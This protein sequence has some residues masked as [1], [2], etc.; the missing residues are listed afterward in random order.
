MNININIQKGEKRAQIR[1][2]MEYREIKR[3]K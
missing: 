1:G 3:I 2:K